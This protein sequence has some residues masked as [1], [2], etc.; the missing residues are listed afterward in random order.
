[1]R[2]NRR[3]VKL[4]GRSISLTFLGVGSILALGLVYFTLV[5]AA[6]TKGQDLSKLEAKS[7]QIKGENERYKVEA[8]R[9]QSLEVIDQNASEKVEIGNSPTAQPSTTSTSTEQQK[10]TINA[11]SQAVRG[12]QANDEEEPIA[13]EIKTKPKF[14]ATQA[15]GFLPVK[16]PVAIK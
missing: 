3:T 12:E 14:I 15:P 6:S 11:E 4:V 1:M 8:A 9:L 2:G 5:G 13:V 16:S 10:V 7:T